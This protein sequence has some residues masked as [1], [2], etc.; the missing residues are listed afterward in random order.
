[1]E[2]DTFGSGRKSRDLLQRLFDDILMKSGE[3]VTTTLS[4]GNK[5]VIMDGR[6]KNPKERLGEEKKG[7]LAAN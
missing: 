2:A 4:S 5:G 1:M 3:M 7:R 6:G